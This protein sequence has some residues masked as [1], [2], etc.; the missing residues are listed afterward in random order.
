MDNSN[1]NSKVSAGAVAGEIE[2]RLPDPRVLAGWRVLPER[3]TACEGQGEL[4]DVGVR[5]EEMGRGERKDRGQGQG[6]LFE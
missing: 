3:V 2:V 6:F 5:R 1:S 4:F